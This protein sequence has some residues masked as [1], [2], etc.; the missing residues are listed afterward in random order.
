[1]ASYSAVIDL[2][3]NG[4][5]KIDSVVAKVNRI[6]GL[7]KGLKPVPDIFQKQRGGTEAFRKQINALKT[8]LSET[9]ATFGQTGKVTGFSKTIGGLNS[10]LATFRS[11]ANSAKAGSQQFTQALTAGENASRQLLKAEL[12][13]L[14]SLQN[15]YQTNAKL[16]KGSSAGIGKQLTE[17]LKIGNT[18][19][20]TTA[21]LNKYKNELQRIISLVEIGSK[22]YKEL[23]RAI[24]DVNKVLAR[25]PGSKQYNEKLRGEKKV[26]QELDKQRAIEDRRFRNAIN[27]IRRRKRERQKQRQ[28]RLLGAGFPLLFGGGLGAVGGSIAGSFAAKPGQEFGAQIFGSAVGQQ[29]ETL[30]KRANALGDAIREISFEKL[31]EQSIIIN[32]ALKDQIKFLKEIG[33]KEK[34]RSL[35]A[36]EVFKRTG[37]SADVNRDINRSVQV[38]NAGFSELV[39]SAGT[40]LAILGAPLLKA[41]GAVSFAV[42]GIFKTF[43]RGISALRSLIQDLPIVDK[44]FQRFDKFL[45]NSA[46]NSARIQRNMNK[47]ADQDFTEL[48]IENQKVIGKNAK[49]FENQRKNL[50]LEK[51]LLKL[52]TRRDFN[53]TL[54]DEGGITFENDPKAYNEIV[55]RFNVQF[56]KNSK[57]LDDQLFIINEQEEKRNAILQRRL[58]LSLAQNNFTKKI[59]KANRE[60]D[61]KTAARLEFERDKVN[62]QFALGEKLREAKSVEE[63]IALIKLH[64]ADIDKL[65]LVLAGKLNDEADKTKDAFQ[66]LSNSINNDIKEGI[67]GLIKGTSTLGDMLNNIADKF[68]D[69]ALNQ[70]LFGSILG[71]QGDKGGGLLGALKLFGNGGR[72]PVGKPSIVGEKGPELFVPRSSGTIVPNNKLGGGGTNNVVVNVDAS[73]S[74]VQGDDAG[75]Q[76]L[77]SLIAAAVQGELVK[78]QRPGGL[79]NR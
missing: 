42:G 47:L 5:K 66:A 33:E 8:T 40:T 13:R 3:V 36:E 7:I 21:A 28:G 11:V 79:L 64:M 76:E 56:Q 61:V 57:T 19:P 45:Q 32:G 30:I 65:R 73:G 78:Q 50:L 67:K 9:L 22:E 2:R 39:N 74:D 17:V 51:D 48:S 37:A 15:L 71:S 31:E 75:G 18:I 6:N 54:Q 49:T 70:G 72:P 14:K 53:Q 35:I 69:L 63:E 27:N 34:A 12:E 58:D 20:K 60:D 23:E 24:A 52:K 41:V 4:E 77:G 1:M 38:L 26:T 16:V 25:V 59:M 55:K 10:Q 44:F 68:L 43:N 46:E 62:L 29:I